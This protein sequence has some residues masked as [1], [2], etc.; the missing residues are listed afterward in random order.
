[1]KVVETNLRK[2][3]RASLLTSENSALN[4]CLAKQQLHSRYHGTAFHDRT[5]HKAKAEFDSHFMD[6]NLDAE[7]NMLQGNNLPSNPGHVSEG[8]EAAKIEDKAY[9]V[10]TKPVTTKLPKSDTTSL[11]EAPNQ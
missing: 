2:S 5:N 7:I 10:M 6:E 4:P 3:K 8:W 1:M 9:E 11:Q